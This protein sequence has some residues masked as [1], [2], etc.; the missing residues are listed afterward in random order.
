[1]IVGLF[2]GIAWERHHNSQAESRERDGALIDEGTLREQIFQRLRARLLES[3]GFLTREELS[4]FDVGD[5]TRR[6]L[7]DTSKGIWNPRDLV[8]TLSIVSSPD[9]PYDDQELSGGLVRYD[10]R[11]GS[12]AG[13]NAKLRRAGDLGIPL[14]WLRK[15]R[16]GAY[17]PVFPVYVVEDDLERRQFLI[18]IDDSARALSSQAQPS[19]LERRYVERVTRQRLHQ[20][21]FRGMVIDAYEVRCAV[22]RLRHGDLL[23]AAHIIADREETGLAIVVNGVSLCKIHHA[24]YDRDLLGISGDYVVHINQRLLDETDGPM[25]KHGLQEMHGQSL[26]LPRHRSSHPDPDRLATRFAA[27]AAV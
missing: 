9:G 12:T 22:C 11:A 2:L 16:S 20:A 21:M 3:G 27:F 14:I 19:E 4:S 23:D 6:R 24:A 13:D 17:I 8:A 10:Y 18:A 26:T 1:M 7:I 15:Y 25:L 5:D